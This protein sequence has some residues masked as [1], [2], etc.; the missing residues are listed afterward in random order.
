DIVILPM[1]VIPVQPV[2]ATLILG[3]AENLV[4]IVPCVRRTYRIHCTIR[5]T[6]HIT[7]SKKQS[8]ERAAL[9][10][11]RVHVIVMPF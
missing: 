10:A 4:D 1:P 7:D 11:V 2:T 8:E 6:P 5:L 3:E 9:F